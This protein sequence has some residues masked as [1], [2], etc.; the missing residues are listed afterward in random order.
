[1]PLPGWPASG[2]ASSD[3]DIITLDRLLS[4]RDARSLPGPDRYLDAFPEVLSCAGYRIKFFLSC[5][6][7]E[8]TSSFY[9]FR[10][11]SITQGR[12]HWRASEVTRFA[13]LNL[14]RQFLL[15]RC[16]GWNFSIMT[17]NRQSIVAPATILKKPW[18]G[19][20]ISLHDE[21]AGK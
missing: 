11:A 18:S 19:S 15:P 5:E 2:R 21:S 8:H 13:S 14:S 1:M 7:R 3:A 12:F 6:L 16:F 17:H 20:T 10:K 4:C 9:A